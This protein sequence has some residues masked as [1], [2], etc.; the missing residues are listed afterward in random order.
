MH[1]LAINPGSTSTKIGIFSAPNIGSKVAGRVVEAMPKASGL[2]TTDAQ[3]TLV[4]KETITH[5]LDDLAKFPTLNDQLDYRANLIKQ[6]V[7]NAG[8]KMDDID[9][10]VGRGGLIRPLESGVYKVDEKLLHDLQIGV[11][12]QHASNLAGQIAHALAAP[13]G[14]HALIADPEVIDELAPVARLSGHPLL[15]RRS[16]FHALNQKAIARRFAAEL[17]KRYDDVN[18][19]VAHLGGGVSVGAHQRGRVIDVNDALDGD[20]P[21]SPERTGNVPSGQLV[22][23]CFSGKHTEAEIKKMLVGQGGYA[24]YLGTNDAKQVAADAK[25]DANKALVQDAMAYQ[26]AKYIASMAA[27]LEGQVDGVLIT[28]GIAYDKDIVE[29]I[30]KRVSFIAPMHVYPGEDEL[31]A[32]AEAAYRAETGIESIKTY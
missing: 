6:A 25:T 9:V 19:V 22:E 8:L 30:R 31:L 16:M 2:E 10:F 12:G 20:G 13:A 28:G 29:A 1:I 15:P 32:L 21:F 23:L 11:Q 24:A 26:V 5:T 4:A 14:K 18:V 27:A 3:L 7:A 17:G